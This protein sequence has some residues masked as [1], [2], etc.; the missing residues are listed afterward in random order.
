MKPAVLILAGLDPT[1]GAGLAADI[2][3]VRACNCHP[4]ILPTALTVQNSFAFTAS[5]PVDPE[6][7]QESF[8]LLLQEFSPAALKIGL[9]PLENTIWIQRIA[10]MLSVV[11]VPMVIDPVLK[12][13]AADSLPQSPVTAFFTFAEEHAAVLTPNTKELAHIAALYQLDPAS[14][15]DTLAARLTA[16]TKLKLAVTFEGAEGRILVAEKGTLHSVYFTPIPLTRQIHG[17]G[18]RFSTALACFLG[19]EQ[20]LLQAVRSAADYMSEIIKDRCAFHPQ[21]QEYLK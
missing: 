13:T 10:A 9:A 19:Q 8:N 7:L 14:S 20:E 12:A 2:S 6:Y 17:T 11:N 3:A 4:L 15:P 18:C 5:Y 16:R 1:G 21:G